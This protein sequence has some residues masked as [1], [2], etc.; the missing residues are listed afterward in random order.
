[1]EEALQKLMETGLTGILL[2]I[3]ISFNYVQYKYNNYLW[4]KMFAFLTD[5]SAKNSTMLQG[6]RDIASYILD[7]VK[8]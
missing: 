1:M 6:I 2:V 3:S 5:F 7:E 4:E 8:K